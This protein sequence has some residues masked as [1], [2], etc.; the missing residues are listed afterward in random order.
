MKTEYEWNS[1][2]PAP[3]HTY[4]VPGVLRVL[5]AANGRRVL[6][7]GCGNGAI[8]QVLSS[9]GFSVVGLDRSISG[10]EHAHSSNDKLEFR[11][12]SIDDPLPADLGQFDVVLSCEVIEH[13]FLPRQLFARARE[14]MSD[15][16]LLVVTTPYHGYLKNL[17]LAV[18]N[19]FD[20]HWSPGWDHGHVKFF[21]KRTLSRLAVEEGFTP[22]RWRLVG[23]IPPLACSMILTARL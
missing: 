23:R 14:A 21:S 19:S 9:E 8:A 15:N 16:G 11:K 3:N 17:G 20:R 2:E 18:T 5:G 12:H 7:L 13:L 22:D 4:L 1:A 10:I 6:D